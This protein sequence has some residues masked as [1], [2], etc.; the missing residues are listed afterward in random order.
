MYN[1][2]T[3]DW[4]Q[5]DAEDYNSNDSPEEQAEDLRAHKDHAAQLIAAMRAAVA[6]VPPYCERYQCEVAE[7]LSRNDTEAEILHQALM[8]DNPTYATS[9][10]V[11]LMDLYDM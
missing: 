10:E 6:Q 2:E 1:P 5:C 8:Q 11:R 3:Y 4:S 9:E 7:D